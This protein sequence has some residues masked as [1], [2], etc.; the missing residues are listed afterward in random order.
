[1]REEYMPVL[2]EN[3]KLVSV[4]KLIEKGHGEGLTQ[5]YI[6]VMDHVR[7]QADTPMRESE[8]YR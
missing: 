8:F 5:G 6:R 3:L 7:N 2:D 1:M 4:L